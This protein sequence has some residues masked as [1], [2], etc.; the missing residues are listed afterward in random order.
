MQLKR[1]FVLFL[2]ILLVF[3][4]APVNLEAADTALTL[5]EVTGGILVAVE[6]GH[7]I[8]WL[9]KKLKFHKKIKH[10]NPPIQTN[11][12]ATSHETN[13]DLGDYNNLFLNLGDDT[14]SIITT[15]TNLVLVT[16]SNVSNM[17]ITNV[18]SNVA[19]SVTNLVATITNKTNINY[20]TNLIL[21]HNQITNLTEQEKQDIKLLGRDYY[22]LVALAYFR[23]KKYDKSKEF[24]L[25][26][27]AIGEKITEGK[28]FLKKNFKFSDKDIEQGIKKYILLRKK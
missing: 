2:L 6:T 13:V 7:L 1:I 27:L 16:N 19:V 26:S 5:I 9:I 28:E 24:M 22:Y 4:I 25:H 12:I 21:T 3:Y 10:K 17:I 15:N 23:V 20:D 11:L 8:Y 18:V 14:N